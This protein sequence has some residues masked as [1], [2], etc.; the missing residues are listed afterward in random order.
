M[1]SN[2]QGT[3]TDLTSKMLCYYTNSS[4]TMQ[5]VRVSHS[6]NLNLEKIVFARQRILFEAMSEGQLEIYT[7]QAGSPKCLKIIPCNSLQV[8][9]VPQKLTV[10]EPSIL[11]QEKSA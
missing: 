10:I 1:S 7:G 11:Y 2:L 6:G 3:T 8:N 9:Q 4:L 5:L